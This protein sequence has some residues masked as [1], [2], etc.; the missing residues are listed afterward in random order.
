YLQERFTAYQRPTYCDGRDR[1]GQSQGYAGGYSR[2]TCP[3]NVW[4]DTLWSY[5]EGD[6][7]LPQVAPD[8][9]EIF[10]NVL[11]RA[12]ANYAPMV[13]APMVARMSLEAISTQPDSDA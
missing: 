8:Y 6:P 11:R 3:R 10:C 9:H 12:R 2:A 13:V 5:M 1:P 7:P 4:L